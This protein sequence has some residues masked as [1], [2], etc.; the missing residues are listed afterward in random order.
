[1]IKLTKDFKEKSIDFANKGSKGADTIFAGAGKDTVLG[2]TGVIYTIGN[3]TLTVK[4][5]KSKNISVEIIE[6]SPV[7]YSLFTEDDDNFISDD[8]QLS[9]ITEENYSVTNVETVDYS[10]LAQ[11]NQKLLT[12]GAKK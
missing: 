9:S 8:A 4:D 3:N 2:G 10:A 5:G 1:M 6:E 12:Y 11:N 7:Y